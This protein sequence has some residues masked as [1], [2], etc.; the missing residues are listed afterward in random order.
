M[1]SGHSWIRILLWTLAGAAAVA[2]L[3]MGLP[4]LLPFGVGL[5]VALLA[6]PLAKLLN[7]KLSRGLASAVAVGSVYGALGTGLW[8]LG[9]GLLLE[10]NRLTDRLP[11]LAQDAQGLLARGEA[12]VYLLG[13]RP[14]VAAAAGRNI[15]ARYPGVT[16]AGCHD[17]YFTDDAE[18]VR[19]IEERSPD[20]LAVCLGSPKQELWMA[21][22][23]GLNAGVML[24]LGGALD[25]LSSRVRRAPASW[26]D[27]GLEWLWRLVRDPRRLKRQ[28]RLPAFLRAVRRQR[29]A[30]WK[31]AD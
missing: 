17:G 30:E 21:A 27:R 25:V 14:G 10:L 15:E 5:A 4:V 23:R 26:R 18:I 16:V 28:I 8:F 19:E 24:G 9:R 2:V 29:K 20:I 3:V 1:F 6:E 31:K 13:G 12:R 7:Q 11:Q 22:R